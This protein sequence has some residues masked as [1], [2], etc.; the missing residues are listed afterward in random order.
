VPLAGLEPATSSVVTTALY[1]LS[2]RGTSA[3]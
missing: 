2:Y 3:K 1:P